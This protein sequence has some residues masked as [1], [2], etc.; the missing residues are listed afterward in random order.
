MNNLFTHKRLNREHR[1]IG[2]MIGLYCRHHHQIKFG[3]CGDCTTLLEYAEKRLNSCPY[4]ADKPTC[5]NCPI[6][7]YKP[8]LRERVRKVMRFAGPRMLWHHPIFATLHLLDK[9]QR[10]DKASVVGRG[11]EPLTANP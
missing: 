5:V 3:L 6:H 4:G 10:T 8:E 7:C 2:H 9:F 11:K 1:T